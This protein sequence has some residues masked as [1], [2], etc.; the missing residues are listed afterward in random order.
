MIAFSCD[1]CGMKFQVKPAFAGRSTACPTCKRPLVVPSA[2]P[3]ESQAPAEPISTIGN[4]AQAGIAGGITLPGLAGDRPADQKPIAA[5]LAEGESTGRRY[6]LQGEIARGGMGAV[7]RAMDCDIRR[8]VA[9]KYLLDQ[10]D[11]RM[12]ARFVEEAQVTGQLEHPN[13]VPIHELGVDAQKRLFFS[14]KRVRGH[15]LA[16]VL[17]E[18]R[19]Y[20]R[21]S[22]REYPLSR[23]LTIFVGVCQALA[24]A[25]SRGVIHRDLKP[26]NVMVGDFG[27]VYVM[28]WGL[29]K[30]LPEGAAPAQSEGLPPGWEDAPSTAPILTSREGDALTQDGAVLGTPAFMSPEQ[31]AGHVHTLD[32]RSDIYALGALLYALLTLEPPVEKGPLLDVLR[33]VR[34][35]QVLPPEQRAPQRARAGKI[36]RELSAVAMK[37]LA[38]RPEDRY[39]R[40]EDLRRDIER[41]QEGR[42]V[43]AREDTIRQALVKFVKRNKA[44]SAMTAVAFLLLLAG[45]AGI[46]RAWWETGQAYAAYQ[47]EQEEKHRRSREAVPAF[48]E[49][50]RLAIERRR[51]PSARTQLDLALEYDPDRADARLLRGQLLIL[52]KEFA[53]A[54]QELAHYLRQRPRDALAARLHY[55]CG[56]DRPDDPGN[57]LTLAQ[58]LEQQ[59]SPALADGLLRRYGGDA[60]EARRFLLKLYQKRIDAAWPALG[61]NL[62]LDATGIFRLKLANCKQVTHLAPLEGMPL[63]WL[64]L[65]YCAGIR[66]LSPLQDMPLTYLDLLRCA[67]VRDLT[68]LKGMP[69]TMLSL[70]DCSLVEDLTPLKGMPLDSLMLSGECKVRD[71]SPLKGMPLTSL[72]L[73][74]RNLIHDLSPLAGMKLHW[75][76]IRNCGAITDLSPLQGM[77]LTTISLM[78]QHLTRGRDVLRQ[79]KSLKTIE[80]GPARY[81]PEE[82]WKRFD[83]GELR[84]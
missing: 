45:A 10:A 76:D 15:S 78:P 77:N 48:V 73:E 21:A 24:Y 44:F 23:L 7:L 6:V 70:A 55:F 30:V 40:V 8:E 81:S 52:E 53:A 32:R 35:G 58:I 41:F 65:R 79:M 54:R 27:E 43:S 4:L 64:S 56:R 28:D 18:L 12:K 69:L 38:K 74:R 31:A 84:Q 42:S 14:M 51:Y 61:S 46:A 17:D 80:I 82:L 66:D 71:L 72:S 33:R 49:A 59:N 68:P 34:E 13:I 39:P 67:Q 19:T 20:P 83:A 60:T 62:S 63:S 11:P 25:H 75:L 26:A 29:A 36:P 1:H 9:V 50:A 3:E 2:D 47:Q 57:L 37:A 22:E 5:V 16:G